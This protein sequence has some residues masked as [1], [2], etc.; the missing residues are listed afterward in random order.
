MEAFTY[1]TRG[2]VNYTNQLG[3]FVHYGY[4]AARRQTLETN[5]NNEVL[6]YKYDPAGN[7]T[8][9]L[10]GK[11]QSTFWGFDQ[12]GRLTSKTNAA[13][14]EVLRYQYDANDRLTN[15][16]T[17]AKG[18]TAYSYDNA[19]KLTAVDYAN[20]TD[21]SFQY[22]ALNHLTNMVD[23]AGTTRFTFSKVA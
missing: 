9:L 15:R 11:L 21:T 4:D 17:T 16:W 13:S 5:A 6:Q 20:S 10:D 8:N 22:D 18:N 1:S 3:R 7:L 23:A 2:L 12:F 19:G 14:V